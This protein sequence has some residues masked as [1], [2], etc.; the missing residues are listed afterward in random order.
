M[1]HLSQMLGKRSTTMSKKADKSKMAVTS[2]QEPYVKSVI[3]LETNPDGTVTAEIKSLNFEKLLRITI[4]FIIGKA[5]EVLAVAAKDPQITPA[6]LEQLKL[7]MYDT[8][9]I[10][11]SNALD[12]FAPDI[13]ARPNLTADAILKAQNEILEDEMKKRGFLTES[14]T[15]NPAFTSDTPPIHKDQL[16]GQMSVED[17]L[18]ANAKKETK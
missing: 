15:P 2:T 3:H 17:I 9:N 10:A 7:T 14:G 8:L 4:P 5:K 6:Q 16:P 18:A 13:E 1:V 12:L 11:F